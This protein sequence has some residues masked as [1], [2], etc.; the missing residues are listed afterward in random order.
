MAQFH[1]FERNLYQMPQ[2]QPLANGILDQRL[3]SWG[4]Q[5]AAWRLSHPS[6]ANR[7]PRTRRASARRARGSWQTAAATT[8]RDALLAL[9]PTPA[10]RRS[11]RIHPPGAP[12]LP[13]RLL[14]EHHRDSA[15]RLQDVRPRD[16]PRGRAAPAPSP[17]AQPPDRR[18][19]RLLPGCGGWPDLSLSN[20]QVNGKRSALKKLQE[21]CKRFKLCP[22]CGAEQGI[23]KRAG[24]SMKIVHDKYS[25]HAELLARAPP[26]PRRRRF[27][28]PA[29]RA[30]RRRRL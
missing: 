14:Q 3:V 29:A 24:T 23:V 22:F 7:E 11:S 9:P 1:V 27:A 19:P 15:V 30:G 5:A 6:A 10:H 21:R 26:S 2:R 18:A 17:P 28:H 20:P 8:V 25:K 13:H 16:G 4:P 12:H